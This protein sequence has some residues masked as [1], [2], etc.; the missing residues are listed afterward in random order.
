MDELLDLFNNLTYLND[1]SATLMGINFFGSPTTPM[2][3]TFGFQ[4]PKSELKNYWDIIPEGT[5]VLIT[6]GPPYGIQD[7]TRRKVNAGCEYLRAEV[8]RKKPKFHFF[9]HI[10]EGRGVEKV[11]ETTFCNAS[12]R[13]QIMNNKKAYFEFNYEFEKDSFSD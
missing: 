11:G 9:G 1:E 6:H 5:D 3:G 12:S 2:Y 13:T 4:K 7:L 10:H 8:E